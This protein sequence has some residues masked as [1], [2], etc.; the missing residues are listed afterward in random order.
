M[1][2][3]APYLHMCGVCGKQ[4]KDDNP[5]SEVRL[6]VR[7]GQVPLCSSECLAKCR[8][9][10]HRTEYTEYV[11]SLEVMVRRATDAERRD[12]ARKE[13]A[14]IAVEDRDE[15]LRALAAGALDRLKWEN[16]T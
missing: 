3:D 8:E 5:F 6:L 12:R 10:S 4:Y 11:A 16:L 15:R 7:E 2:P 13:L 14:R 9:E 1:G